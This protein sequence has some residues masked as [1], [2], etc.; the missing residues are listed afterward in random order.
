M[1]AGSLLVVVWLLGK[2]LLAVA[3]TTN[4]TCDVAHNWAFNSQKQSPCQVASS[5]LAV[6]TG[7]YEVY[8]LPINFHYDGPDMQDANPC[9]CNTVVY[10]LLAECGL[11]QERTITMWSLWETNCASVSISSFPMPLP[12]GLHVPGWAY[13]DVETSDSF[14]ET[15]AFANSNITEST[16][17]PQGASLA[18]VQHSYWFAPCLSGY[19]V[20]ERLS[21][22]AEK[23]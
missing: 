22:K 5:L 18:V 9:Q 13:L 20:G 16:A 10:S 23:S 19:I 11:C 21:N 15:L 17:I 3:Q 14:N 8:A 2:N 4:A 7:S 6:C 12:A 1:F